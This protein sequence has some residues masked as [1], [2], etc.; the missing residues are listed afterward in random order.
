MIFWAH[1]L[2]L[3]FF[4]NFN[5]LTTCPIFD[6]FYSTDRKTEKLNKGL[7]IG[8]WPKRMPGRMCNIVH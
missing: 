3:A 7:V 1:F 5:F 4:E 2:L 6:D 8:F